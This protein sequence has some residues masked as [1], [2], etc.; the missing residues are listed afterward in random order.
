MG[1]EAWSLRLP[2]DLL[3][4]K[5]RSE[6]V[7]SEVAKTLAPRRNIKN[8][9]IIKGINVNVVPKTIFFKCPKSQHHATFL[10]DSC[11]EIFMDSL[12]S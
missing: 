3:S 1:L 11:M 10:I 12:K 4:Q 6:S 2:F 8:N 5:E 7:V 9:E